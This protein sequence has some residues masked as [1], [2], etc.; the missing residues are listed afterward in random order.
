MDFYK[1]VRTQWDRAAAIVLLVAG[2]VA[3]ILGWVGVS[4][5][6]LP[7]EQLPYLSSDGLF[8]IFALGVAATLWL[9]ADLRDEWR[10]LDDIHREIRAQ[11]SDD[12]D[13]LS[14]SGV[15]PAQATSTR[16]RRPA[17]TADQD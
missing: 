15:A 9:S 4:G 13:E 8:G 7:T 6:T 1:W 16:S 17:V 12:S 5:A 10:K 14:L 3:L 11:R 2:I